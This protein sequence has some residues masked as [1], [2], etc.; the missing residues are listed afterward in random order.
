MGVPILGLVDAVGKKLLWRE[1]LVLMDLS[2]LPEGTVSKSLC[3]G[4]ER[5]AA[6]SPARLT[7]LEAYGWD[8]GL[9]PITF[10][11]ERM[12]RCRRPLSWA[13]AAAIR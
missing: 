2:L 9:K 1:V 8:G 5:S 7:V 4:H 3:P 11:A 13:V 6:I 12:I 10:S